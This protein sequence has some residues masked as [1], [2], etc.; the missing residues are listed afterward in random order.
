MKTTGKI[1]FLTP[2]LDTNFIKLINNITQRCFKTYQMKIET[3]G[4]QNI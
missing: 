2:A 3:A 4:T 1:T